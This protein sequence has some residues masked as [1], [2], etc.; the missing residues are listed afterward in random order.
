M[1]LV[2]LL[3]A[4][5]VSAEFRFDDYHPST[6]EKAVSDYPHDSS[7]D[8]WIEAANIKYRVR[9]T[10]TG[11]SRPLEAEVARLLD[12]WAKALQHTD[13]RALLVHEIE[14]REGARRYWLPIHEQLLAPLGRE[15]RPDG[16]ADLFVWRIGSLR[17]GPVFLVNEFKSLGSDEDDR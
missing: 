15:V 16:L 2:A 4:S 10:V 14:V 9:V 8:Q 11:K 6:L 13:L 5:T 7:A 17:T 3:L 1:T 12:D